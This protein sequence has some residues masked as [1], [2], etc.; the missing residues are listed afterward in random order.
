MRIN[1]FKCEE[2][3]NMHNVEQRIIAQMPEGWIT[4]SQS[5]GKEDLHFCST[6]CLGKWVDVQRTKFTSHWGKLNEGEKDA[7]EMLRNRVVAN[8]ENERVKFEQGYP[9]LRLSWSCTIDPFIGKAK[10]IEL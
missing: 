5:A 9:G 4:L 8:L 7:V 3:N 10:Y 1:A 2:C 6:G